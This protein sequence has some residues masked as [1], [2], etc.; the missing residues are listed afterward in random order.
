[1]SKKVAIILINWNSFE[2]TH[3]CIL[4]LKE[5]SC[6][7]YDII[8]VDN[9][10]TDHSG[11]KLKELHPGIIYIPS[12]TNLGFTGGNNLGLQYSINNHYTYSLLLNNDTFVEKDFLGFLVEYMDM[13]PEAGAIQ[14]KIFFQHNR[15]MLWNGGSYYNKAM[16]I[17][18]SKRYMLPEGKA[19]QKIQQ[20]DW[21][22]GCALMARNNLLKSTGLLADNLFIYYEDVDL[23]F[24]IRQ[25]GY[26]LIFHPRAVMY[27]IAGMSNKSKIKGKEGY[28][29]PFVHYLN[30]R[31]RIWLLKKYT[32]WYY[33]PGVTIYIFFY[34]LA[35]MG[36]FA[37]R[38]RITKL[39]SV[40]KGIK[41]GL[42]GNIIYQ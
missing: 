16:G 40:W 24:R 15:K 22:T 31:N 33:I 27:H 36:Y 38:W 41:D 34:F 4:S 17:T 5:L 37:T 1:M 11:E 35:V 19:Q 10:S 13:H 29:S 3:N 20:V 2:Y 26:Q 39:Q 30:I 12:P 14:P 25:A 7:D 28:L 21:I 9:G 18:Y 8:V 42:K 32:P 6:S 23:S